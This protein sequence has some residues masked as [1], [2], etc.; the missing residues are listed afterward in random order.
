MLVA[1][2][3]QTTK[4]VDKFLKRQGDTRFTLLNIDQGDNAAGLKQVL[5]D[6]A[7][8]IVTFLDSADSWRPRKLEIQVAELIKKK[9]ICNL[10]DADVVDSLGYFDEVCRYSTG[11]Y[12]GG[13]QRNIFFLS[14]LA[15]RVE[16]LLSLK[17]QARTGH[18]EEVLKLAFAGELK[19]HAIQESL[20]LVEKRR[21]RHS[22]T[23]FL[24]GYNSKL[25]R[26]GTNL[27]HSAMKSLGKSHKSKQQVTVD[28]RLSS[29]LGPTCKS[30]EL[31]AYLLAHDYSVAVYTDLHQSYEE[32]KFS[33]N[34]SEGPKRYS[35]DKSIHPKDIYL[36]LMV[37]TFPDAK[38]RVVRPLG[39]FAKGL[40]LT[41]AIFSSTTFVHMDFALGNAPQHVYQRWLREYKQYVGKQPGIHTLAM[42]A[43]VYLYIRLRPWVRKP[44]GAKTFEYNLPKH[45]YT[46]K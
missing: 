35:W 11:E 36:N 26:F 6:M 41:K 46:E 15:V 19:S 1:V 29:L 28:L 20:C 39:F 40:L 30:F 16:A 8:S 34:G 31:I 43:A 4:E 18:A 45:L 3:N 12:V 14:T 42:R 9:A 32:N 5:D 25:W 38:V 17:I 2:N 33:N 21:D 22:K 7:P 37:G 10:C 23:K 44:L 27:I 13:R 24:I